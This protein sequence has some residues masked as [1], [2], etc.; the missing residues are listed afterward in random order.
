M[1]ARCP[2]LPSYRHYWQEARSDN[3]LQKNL[4]YSRGAKDICYCTNAD[5]QKLSESQRS[6][7]FSEKS[8]ILSEISIP[9]NDENSQE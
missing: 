8:G 5:S 1:M 7:G 4:F 6:Q 9:R 2:V 3:Y